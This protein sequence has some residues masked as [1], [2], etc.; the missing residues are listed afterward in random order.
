MSLKTTCEGFALSWNMIL[1]QN[2]SDTKV[3]P[4]KQAIQVFIFLL[5]FLLFCLL[6]KDQLRSV[7]VTA[8]GNN[9]CSL[10]RYS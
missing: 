10:V 8:M 9:A 2:L 1:T 4:L 6:A 5:I 3:Y 7:K